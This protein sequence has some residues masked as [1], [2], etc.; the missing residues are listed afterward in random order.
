MINHPQYKDY[1][2][3]KLPSIQRLHWW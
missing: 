3:D 1:I 2:D